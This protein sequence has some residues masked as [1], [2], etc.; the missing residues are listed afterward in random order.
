MANIGI[1][2]LL[3]KKKNDGTPYQI[4]KID[5]HELF[6]FGSF[7][8]SNFAGNVCSKTTGNGSFITVGKW[9]KTDLGINIKINGLGTFK[10]IPFPVNPNYH[11]IV[12]FDKAQNRF[13][14]DD[15]LIPKNSDLHLQIQRVKKS[16]LND[17][18]FCMKNIL[19]YHTSDISF[20]IENVTTKAHELGV[21]YK[22]LTDQGLTIYFYDVNM[23]VTIDELTDS[24]YKIKSSAFL[25]K[26]ENQDNNSYNLAQGIFNPFA[27]SETNTNSYD[28]AN[29]D[30]EDYS[31]TEHGGA[32][33][34]DDDGINTAFEGDP[35][36]YWNVD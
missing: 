27:L 8:G 3:N 36:N 4:F 25:I 2:Y 31:T 6:L 22:A 23:D 1:G 32:Y 5:D 34:F 24:T 13:L 9:S 18:F 30:F 26:R 11:Y 10:A 19:D 29:Y 21:E 20:N 7:W 33:G 16:F 35:E 28:D 15:N 12:I 14:R 17:S